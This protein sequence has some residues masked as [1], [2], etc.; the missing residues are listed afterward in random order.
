MRVHT[1]VQSRAGI[2]NREANGV[3]VDIPAQAERE[4]LRLP[5]LNARDILV[6]FDFSDASFALLR[7]LA[8]VAEQTKATLHIVHVSDPESSGLAGDFDGEFSRCAA[9]GASA[10]PLLRYWAGKIMGDRVP[11]STWVQAGAPADE[12]TV[13]ARA[14]SVDL[15][16]MTTHGYGRLND[17][18]L[19]STTE[20]VTRQA[21]CPVL[22]IPESELGRIGPELDGFPTSNWKRI[23]VR[24]ELS[25]AGRAGL[26]YAAAIALRNRA[27]LRFLNVLPVDRTANAHPS[28]VQREGQERLL[29]WVRSHLSAPLE[30][31]SAVWMGESPL[32]AVLLEAKRFRADLIV[33]PTRRYDWAKRLRIGSVTD[34]ILRH[35]PCAVLSIH[36]DL[37]RRMATVEG[38]EQA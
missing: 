26:Q 3:R 22:T 4:T 1:P 35:A 38:K 12:I 6:P 29:R 9:L 28:E 17:V 18:F 30:F 31:E 33:L 15:I 5:V 37:C 8:A 23:L 25:Q 34:G 10:E 7:R 32:C 14:L 24:L 27:A 21:P 2:A 13:M 16:V 20:R 11:F 36:E 19:R